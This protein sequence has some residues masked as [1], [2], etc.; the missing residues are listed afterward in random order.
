MKVALIHYWLTSWRGGEAVLSAIAQ[1]YPG[2]D[3]FAHVVDQDLIE[4]HFPGRNVRTTFIDSLP[5]SRRLYQKYLPLMPLALEA[6]DLREYDL[7]IS[8]EAGPAK[9]VITRPES[10]HVC[11]CHS[12]MRYAWDMYHEYRARSPALTRFMMSPVMHYMRMWDQLSAQRVDQFVANSRFVATRIHK[13]YGRDAVVIPPPVDVESFHALEAHDDYFLWVGQLVPYKRPDLMV[14]SFNRLKLPLRVIGEGP[15]LATLKKRAGLN[16]KFLGRQ[17][18]DVVVEHYARCRALV[19]PGTE[20]FGIVPVEAMASGRP[21]IAYARGGALD[22]VI[23]DVTGVLFPDQTVA[24]LT[25][26]VERFQSI[27]AVFDPAKL[28]THAAQFSKPHFQRSFRQLVDSCLKL[29]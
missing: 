21:V 9:G 26:A 20:D 6:L 8:S 4:D 13:Y 16:I 27:E 15:E 3:I 2:A 24:G 1:L 19:F 23:P 18:L 25:A 14:E 10:V 17:P 29:A 7:I 11:Y 5:W 12:P 28:V 22:T